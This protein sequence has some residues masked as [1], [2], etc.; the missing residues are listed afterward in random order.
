MSEFKVSVSNEELTQRIQAGE[1]GLMP[2]LWEQ[3]ERFARKTARPFAGQCGD[4]AR[5]MEDLTQEG[6]LA[7]ESAVAKYQDT[8]GSFLTYYRFFLMQRYNAWISDYAGPVALPQYVHERGRKLVRTESNMIA[9]QGD[10]SIQ[11]LAAEMGMSAGQ[12]SET[13]EILANVGGYACLDG[14]MVGLEDVTLGEM[15]PTSENI[16]EMVIGQQYET[17]RRRIVWETV[18]RYCTPREVFILKQYYIDILPL[19]TIAARLGISSERVRVIRNDAVRK[20]RRVKAA[21]DLTEKLEIADCR[22]YGRGAGAS[23]NSWTSSTEQTVLR[24]LDAVN[25][26]VHRTRREDENKVVYMLMP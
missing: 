6:Y 5:A 12:A 22:A 13:M 11:A 1:Y 2:Q 25:D 9:G 18:E 16:E 26:I 3:V 10:T 24:R 23:G 21:R 19:S 15:L 8:G 7:L 4:P 20:L 17:E 14:P